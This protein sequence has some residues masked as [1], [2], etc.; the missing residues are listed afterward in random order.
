MLCDV[1]SHV[2]VI[3]L[4]VRLSWYLLNVDVVTVM[5]VLMFMLDMS[6]L[7]EYEGARVNN[8]GVGNGEGVVWVSSGH[9]YVGGTHGS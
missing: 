7:R 4:S 8:A 6:M 2:V 3:D 1:C 5:R 9:E